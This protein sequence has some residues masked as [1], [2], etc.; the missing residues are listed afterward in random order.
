M[1]ENT[2]MKEACIWRA[3]AWLVLR[4]AEGTGWPAAPRTGEGRGCE[5]YQ[6]GYGTGD[7]RAQGVGTVV[8]KAA[9]S[10]WGQNVRGRTSLRTK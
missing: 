6:Q 5:R 1:E 2:A 9:Y 7:K 3:A 10:S 8:T 4:D